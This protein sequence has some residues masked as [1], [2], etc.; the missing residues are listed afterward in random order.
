MKRNRNVVLSKLPYTENTCNTNYGYRKK[1]VVTEDFESRIIKDT[2]AKCFGLQSCLKS[3]R[4]QGDAIV[5][6][7]ERTGL[8]ISFIKDN[9]EQIINL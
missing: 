6:L 7:S 2:F 5:A 9:L 8:R 1:V 3:V 4:T